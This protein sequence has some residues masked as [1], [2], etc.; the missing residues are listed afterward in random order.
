MEHLL[1]AFVFLAS[2]VLVLGAMALLVVN[3]FTLRLCL[4]VSTLGVHDRRI[5]VHDRVA[6]GGRVGSLEAGVA[7]YGVALRQEDEEGV[8]RRVPLDRQ[9]LQVDNLVGVHDLLDEITCLLIIHRPDFLNALVISFLEL[10]EAFLQLDELVGEELVL[11][12]VGRVEALSL[13][14]LLLEQLDFVM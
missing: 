10:F 9:L 14:L 5:L 8:P 6:L 4:V 13:R 1:H 7:S 3:K 12:R 11:L 2:G